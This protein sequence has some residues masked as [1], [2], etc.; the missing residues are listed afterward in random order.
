M[1]LIRGTVFLCAW[2]ALAQAGL[3]AETAPTNN[4]PAVV[5]PAGPGIFEIGVIRLDSI[6]R[7]ISF[8]A[9]VNMREGQIEYLVVSSIG[10]LHESIFKTQAEPFHIHTA[11]LLLNGNS[12]TSALPV[13]ANV[14]LESRSRPA[15]EFVKNTEKDAPMEQSAWR[16]RGSRI[17]EGIFLAQR[18]GSILALIEDADALVDNPGPDAKKDEIWQPITSLLP[19]VGHSVR[20]TLKFPEKKKE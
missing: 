12:N 16:Y 20:I 10:K 2:L 14:E 15:A 8:P 3:G 17:T 4:P 18:D 6:K 1:N 5:R 9:E 7:E 11:A 19:P 13:E